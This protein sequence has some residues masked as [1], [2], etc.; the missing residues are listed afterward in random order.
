MLNTILDEFSK[1]DEIFTHFP[2]DWNAQMNFQLEIDVTEE[3]KSH[4]K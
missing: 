2:S 4:E 3:K 1:T